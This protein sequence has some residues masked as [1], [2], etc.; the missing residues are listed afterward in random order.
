MIFYNKNE[1][2]KVVKMTK[3]DK[4]IGIDMRQVKYIASIGHCP[5]CGSNSVKFRL[6][7]ESYLATK[8]NNLD[9]VVLDFSNPQYWLRKTVTTCLECGHKFHLRDHNNEFYQ[10]LEASKNDEGDSSVKWSYDFE[11]YKQED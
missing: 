10:G 1:K 3:N 4:K 7:F 2:Q 5:K 6:P 11:S 9:K 8:D